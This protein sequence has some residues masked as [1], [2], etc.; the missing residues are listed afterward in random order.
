MISQGKGRRQGADFDLRSGSDTYVGVGK[1]GTIYNYQIQ[2]VRPI[3]SCA[4]TYLNS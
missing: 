3:I 2:Q 1:G 4:Y